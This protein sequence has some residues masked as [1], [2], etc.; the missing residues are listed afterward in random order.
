[1]EFVGLTGDYVC[2][3]F[4]EKIPNGEITRDAFE[5]MVFCNQLE[6]YDETLREYAASVCCQAPVL[7]SIC[8]EYPF[9]SNCLH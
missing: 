5:E 9:C 8:E 2:D 7:Y 3:E 4:D 6:R 1:M